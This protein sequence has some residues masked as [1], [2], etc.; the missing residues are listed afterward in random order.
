MLKSTVLIVLFSY[1]FSGEISAQNHTDIVDA[2]IA[3]EGVWVYKTDQ[4]IMTE[5]WNFVNDSLFEGTTLVTD[6]NLNPVYTEKMAIRISGKTVKYFAAVSNQNNASEIP[7]ELIKAQSYIFTFENPQ[8]DYPQRI[9][10]DLSVE[11]KLNAYIE[12]IVDGIS[13]RDEFNFEGVKD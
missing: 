7:F 6:V 3:F 9:V 13:R 1:L 12:G 10:Y 11:G 8:H 5:T 4:S 2:L